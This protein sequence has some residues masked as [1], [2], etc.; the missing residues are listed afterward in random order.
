MVRGE[1]GWRT[2]KKPVLSPVAVGWAVMQKLLIDGV[3]REQMLSR[4]AWGGMY[5]AERGLRKQLG[6]DVADAVKNIHSVR[7]RIAG[8]EE[9]EKARMESIRE[10][11]SRLIAD[12]KQ[13]AERELQGFTRL[14]SELCAVLGVADGSSYHALAQAIDL[15]R[16][17]VKRDK[18]FSRASDQLIRARRELDNAIAS[19]APPA[20][21]D[22]KA[23][24]EAGR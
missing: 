6:D 22:V 9:H 4:R 11:E 12:M 18:A 7:E 1:S 14:H 17:K 13:R 8:M 5:A 19:V 15:L 2:I 23:A 20:L 16:D 21:P 10:R 24:E 3:H